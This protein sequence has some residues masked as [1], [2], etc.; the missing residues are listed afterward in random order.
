MLSRLNDIHKSNNISVRIFVVDLIKGEKSLIIDFYN[1]KNTNN[2]TKGLVPG[3]KHW[4]LR[5]SVLES[6]WD[7]WEGGGD[8]NL[9]E[10]AV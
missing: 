9:T 1:L 6:F 3:E 8:E 7:E 5:L 2:S 10:P 4:E